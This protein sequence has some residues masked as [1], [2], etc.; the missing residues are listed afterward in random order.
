MVYINFIWKNEAYRF[1][2]GMNIVNGKLIHDMV[3]KYDLF[4]IKPFTNLWL[5]D[6]NTS[7]FITDT[8]M[9]VLNSKSAIVMFDRLIPMFD[10]L[11]NKYVPTLESITVIDPIFSFT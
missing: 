2:L 11:Q 1:P 9:I 5:E 7:H 10:Q 3:I 6:G 4:P 8:T